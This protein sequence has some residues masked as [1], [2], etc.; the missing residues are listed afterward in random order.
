VREPDEGEQRLGRLQA[1]IDAALHESA[2]GG[3]AST[4][5]PYLAEQEPGV[6][7]HLARAA[8]P[9][10][11]DGLEAM[12][13]AYERLVETEDPGRV[14]HALMLL[15][16]HHPDAARLGLRI[17]ALEQRSP[18]KVRPSRPGN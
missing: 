7:Q 1:R 8:A 4:F 10:G 5:S 16:T 12:M 14:Q 13:D 6:A 2:S 18:S 17:P 11:L 9:G 3:K 15:L